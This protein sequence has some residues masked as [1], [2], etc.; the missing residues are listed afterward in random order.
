[1]ALKFTKKQVV[2][3]VGALS[4]LSI[5]FG[6]VFGLAAIDSTSKYIDFDH[7]KYTYSYFDATPQKTI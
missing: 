5:S 3:I 2:K 7:P 1:M 4:I 6:I